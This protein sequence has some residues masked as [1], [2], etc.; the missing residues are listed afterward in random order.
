MVYWLWGKVICFIKMFC[1]Y[2]LD[3]VFLYYI[4]IDYF[5]VF[6]ILRILYCWFGE[7]LLIGICLILF[8]VLYFIV[9]FV[10]EG[11]RSIFVIYVVSIW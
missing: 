10:Y 6:C 4:V 2:Y 3:V 8:I 5:N 9:C 1:F 7:G 11:V